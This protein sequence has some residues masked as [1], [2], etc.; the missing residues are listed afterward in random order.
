[1]V[2]RTA[3]RI[4]TIAAGVLLLGVTV[5][6][7]QGYGGGSG[8]DPTFPISTP[9]QNYGYD[10]LLEPSLRLNDGEIE[11]HIPTPPPAEG[12][13]PNGFRSGPT[14]GGA[15]SVVDGTKLGAAIVGPR[16]SGSIYSAKQKANREIRRLI[17]ELEG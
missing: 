8:A 4:V 14:A 6:G 7:A 3:L 12:N 16:G 10:R 5:A 1:L 11:Y 15:D 2:V 17:R 13:G 9:D